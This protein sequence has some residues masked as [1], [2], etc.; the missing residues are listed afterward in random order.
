MGFKR[1]TISESEHKERSLTLL[2]NGVNNRQDLDE[3]YFLY[4]DILTPRKQDKSC[5]SCRNYVW[6]RLK[7]HY[8]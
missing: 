6:T 2:K 4:N 7:E 8:K 3:L 1:N 5:G